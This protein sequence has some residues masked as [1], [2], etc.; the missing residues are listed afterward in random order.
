MARLSR[1]LSPAPPSAH[2]TVDLGAV[3]VLDVGA[4]QSATLESRSIRKQWH[5][6]VTSISADAVGLE[7]AGSNSARSLGIRGSRCRVANE[8]SD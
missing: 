1:R 5:A 2:A 6:G 4:E 7:L 3:D 8:A